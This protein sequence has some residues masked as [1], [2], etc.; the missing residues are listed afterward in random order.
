MRELNW[1]KFRITP[2]LVLLFKIYN[3]M[4]IPPVTKNIIG[5]SAIGLGI[6]AGLTVIPKTVFNFKPIQ[7][8]EEKTGMGRPIL[9]DSKTGDLFAW[10]NT[11][12]GNSVFAK[13][14]K[15][16]ES[17]IT[18]KVYEEKKPDKAPVAIKSN[19][20]RSGRIFKVE[21]SY[22]S[23]NTTFD[24]QAQIKYRSYEGRMLYRVSFTTMLPEGQKCPT[25]A[26]G[27]QLKQIYNAANRNVLK[28]RVNDSDKF[29][30]KDLSAPLGADV[31]NNKTTT[32]IDS[33]KGDCAEPKEL[34][35][36]GRASNFDLPGFNWVDN[37]K[38][39]FSSVKLA[40]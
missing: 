4:N 13:L 32:V 35:F 40:K 23:G 15:T 18:G 25:K 29:W 33:F 37:G 8:F 19:D 38:L 1:I 12:D 34:I 24:V 20:V 6:V 3:Q 9:A 11:P 28:F 31:A 10:L 30:V 5:W 7:R 26:E 27:N 21:D 22:K 17:A 39:L 36:H 2:Q 16:S 14:D